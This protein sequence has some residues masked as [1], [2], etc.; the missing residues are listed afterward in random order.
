MHIDDLY[1]KQTG[2][3]GGPGCLQN[4]KKH[5]GRQEPNRNSM[6]LGGHGSITCGP[7]ACA[8]LGHVMLQVAT[9]HAH[10]NPNWLST[11][12]SETVIRSASC[13]HGEVQKLAASIACIHAPLACN[14]RTLQEMRGRV[15]R[16]IACILRSQFNTSPCKL[17]DDFLIAKH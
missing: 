13:T 3:C 7:R 14:G 1:R 11:W 12:P 4:R 5:N 16:H 8:G 10:E 2:N 15:A 9:A 6:S 17:P